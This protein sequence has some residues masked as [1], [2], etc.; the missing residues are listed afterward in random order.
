MEDKEHENK[1]MEGGN[2]KKKRFV[3]VCRVKRRESKIIY[4]KGD[5]KGE[6]NINKQ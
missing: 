3:P 5:Q 1:S 2:K 4:R 6:K